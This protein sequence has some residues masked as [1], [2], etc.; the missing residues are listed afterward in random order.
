MIRE[1]VRSRP[2]LNRI[3][4]IIRFAQAVPLADVGTPRARAAFRVRSN[5]LLDYRR[6]AALHAAAS[7]ALPGTFV[8]CGVW[9][10]G[11][12]GMMGL[13]D[14][15]RVMWLFD[16]WQ[17][18]PEPD[19]VD[20]SVRG[21]RRHAGWNYADRAQV[22]QLLFGKLGLDRRRVHLVQRWFEE[23]LPAARAEIGPIA[24]LHLDGDWYASIKT[25][26]EMLYDDV[27]QGG[28][29][30][31]DDY[32]HWKGCAQAVDEFLAT[33]EPVQIRRVEV[34]ALWRKHV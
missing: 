7:A 26:L 12:A 2:A 34:A 8:E 31:V 33:R 10:G 17:G 28:F 13:A 3:R 30:I 5:T 18:L 27:T 29:V 20:V 25:C 24:L 19:A 21:H 6:L 14:P 23:T 15:R 9:A 16:S 1:F 32:F 11:S 22:E 4:K